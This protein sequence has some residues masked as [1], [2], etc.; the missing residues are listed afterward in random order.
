MLLWDLPAPNPLLH[1]SEKRQQSQTLLTVSL[2]GSSG[3]NRFDPYWKEKGLREVGLGDISIAEE[4][5][6]QWRGEGPE[7][8]ILTDLVFVVKQRLMLL[9]LN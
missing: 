2:Q 4:A 3:I 8:R 9:C 1:C 7:P 6:G 5:E